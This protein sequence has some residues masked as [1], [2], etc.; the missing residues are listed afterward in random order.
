MLQTLLDK[1]PIE[2]IPIPFTLEWKKGPGENIGHKLTER[3]F[4]KEMIKNK[5]EIAFRSPAGE[6]GGYS[7]A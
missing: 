6:K 2:S 3:E 5:T 7:G 1:P 4:R